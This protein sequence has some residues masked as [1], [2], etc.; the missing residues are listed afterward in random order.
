MRMCVRAIM[1][2][3]TFACLCAYLDIDGLQHGQAGGQ[4]VVQD[5][6][7]QLAQDGLQR[8]G[9]QPPHQRR[10][11]SHLSSSST[12]SHIPLATMVVTWRRRRRRGGGQADDDEEDEEQS[13]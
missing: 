3:R 6:H 5:V 4:G 8:D 9:R 7:R 1:L 2:A 12:D 13:P 11:L 10:A